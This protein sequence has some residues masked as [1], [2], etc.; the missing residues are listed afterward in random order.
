[1]HACMHILYELCIMLY[2]GDNV[3]AYLDKPPLDQ[4]TIRHINCSIIVKGSDQRCAA[5]TKHR[6]SLRAMD[7]RTKD[8]S[9]VASK[10]DPKS[11]V[12]Y[13]YLT[14]TEMQIRLKLLHQNNQ[15]MAR[16]LMNMRKKL[17]DAISEKSVTLNG[18]LSEDL[19]DVMKLHSA[20]VKSENASNSF[21]HIFWDQ[22]LQAAT[23]DPRGMRWHPLMI[24][25]YIYLCHKSS[26]AYDLLRS[27]GI[28]SLP[29]TRTLRDYTHYISPQAGF[30]KEVD[31]QLMEAAQTEGQDE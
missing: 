16:Q 25:W 20:T 23:R 4:P 22:Q 31:E 29:S 24:R 15:R 10:V 9:S 21:R 18:N 13:R 1:M 5:C 8:S 6:N 7:S 26:G 14:T 11:H 12:N 19:V 27:S 17:E 28:V 30:S 3:N 2:T